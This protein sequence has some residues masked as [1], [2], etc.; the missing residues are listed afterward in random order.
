VG[1][2]PFIKDPDVWS[3]LE[4]DSVF[5][6]VVSYIEFQMQDAIYSPNVMQNEMY[7]S[8]SSYISEYSSSAY[9]SVYGVNDTTFDLSECLTLEG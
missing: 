8:V 6:S 9:S 1:F 2:F 3:L 7:N 4:S 5:G